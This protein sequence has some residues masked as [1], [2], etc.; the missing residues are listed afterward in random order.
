MLGI[1]CHEN[2][3]RWLLSCKIMGWKFQVVFNSLVS[4]SPTTA[5]PAASSATT[6]LLAMKPGR[7]AFVLKLWSNKS[8]FALPASLNSC[9]ASYN[10]ASRSAAPQ[11][12]QLWSKSPACIHPFVSSLASDIANCISCRHD[13]RKLAWRAAP[14]MASATRSPLLMAPPAKTLDSCV[15]INICNCSNPPTP[16]C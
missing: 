10:I 1:D 5:L 6:T 7:M 12:Y 4:R 13:V 3:E 15:T 11:H 14:Q 8:R 9:I 16:T 2:L